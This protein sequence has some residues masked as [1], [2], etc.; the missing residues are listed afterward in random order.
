MT[1]LRRFLNKPDYDEE[2][3]KLFKLLNLD[4]TGAASEESDR[5]HAYRDLDAVYQ[6][7]TSGGKVFIGN[8][9]ASKTL[10]ILQDNRITHVVNCTTDMPN[11]FQDKD[12]G[13]S[14]YRFDIYKYRSLDLKTHRGVQEF[15]LP[16]FE[17]IDLQVGQGRNVLI[18]CLAGAHRAGTTGVAYTM[19]ATN[20]DHRTA[21]T[22]VK[23]CRR[24]VDPIGD[25][26]T[27]LAR[28][29]VGYQDPSVG[30]ELIPKHSESLRRRERLRRCW[31]TGLQRL[32][33]RLHLM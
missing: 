27:L 30:E 32:R 23:A 13:I 1:T 21:I 24:I 16:V 18:H 33:R 9:R 7:P 22:A 19:H 11:V 4:G 15:F 20:L 25:L 10:R 14:Y 6:H 26:T 12:K 3:R 2:A 31:E 17:W 28:L 5:V 29:E 8:G